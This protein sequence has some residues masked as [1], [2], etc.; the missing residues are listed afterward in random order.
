MPISTDA[1]DIDERSFGAKRTRP[2]DDNRQRTQNL[3]T[4][5][6]QTRPDAADI[7]E[8]SFGAKRTRP[9]DD[10]RQRKEACKNRTNRTKLYLIVQTPNQLYFSTKLL[11]LFSSFVV[12]SF[13]S[14]PPWRR[15]A[16]R[17]GDGIESGAKATRSRKGCESTP[18]G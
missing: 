16:K 6:T 8:R 10:N 3:C 4:R 5:L 15:E 1:A 2:R 13:G 18:S 12:V 11:F 7:D 9:R 17:S 14:M